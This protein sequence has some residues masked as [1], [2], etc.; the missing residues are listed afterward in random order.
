MQ[1]FFVSFFVVLNQTWKLLAVQLDCWLA[2]FLDRLQQ[3]QGG[4]HRFKK[5]PSITVLGN[6]LVKFIWRQ[7]STIRGEGEHFD[8]CNEPINDLEMRVIKISQL[9]ETVGSLLKD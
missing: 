6:E 2:T 8:Y 4:N 9:N 1:L 5:V 3:I 7:R